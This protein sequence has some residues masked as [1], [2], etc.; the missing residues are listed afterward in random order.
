V[1]I[2]TCRLRQTTGQEIGYS[3]NWTLNTTATQDGVTSEVYAR[4][5]HDIRSIHSNMLF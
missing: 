3:S 5:N 1:A 2:A 4:N